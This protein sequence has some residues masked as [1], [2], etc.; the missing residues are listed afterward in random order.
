MN[1][2]QISSQL[3]A[4]SDQTQKSRPISGAFRRHKLRRL[5]SNNLQSIPVAG[6]RR[7]A[8]KSWAPVLQGREGPHY[9]AIAD[10]IADDVAAG[11]LAPGDRLPPQRDL[12]GRLELDFTTVARGYVEAG[13]RGLVESVVGRGTFVRR[14]RLGPRRCRPTA[15]ARRLHDEHAAR[16]GRPGIARADAGGVRERRRRSRFAAALPGL[17]RIADG[18]RRGRELAR[19]A[20][21]R[22]FAGAHIPRARRAWRA[23][24]HLQ[25]AGAAGDTVLCEAITY[26]GVR[27]IARSSACS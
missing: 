27:A 5:A 12:A 24:R 17:R 26:P 15:L 6:D 21:A 13:K 20:R 25:P 1:W 7:N 16:A 19:T 9:L 8:M 11:R 18:P 3:R 10:V 23:G 22:A 4:A 14:T 2:V